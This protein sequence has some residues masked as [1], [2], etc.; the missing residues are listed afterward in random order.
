MRRCERF[1]LPALFV[2][3][4]FLCV[5]LGFVIAGQVSKREKLEFWSKICLTG[6]AGLSLI[7]V[8]VA[9]VLIFECKF[10]IRVEHVRETTPLVP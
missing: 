8:I 6:A 9:F 7:L 3:F 10:V 2:I 5:A 4:I 1:A